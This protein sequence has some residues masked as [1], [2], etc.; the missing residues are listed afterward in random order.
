[1]LFKLIRDREKGGLVMAKQN[2]ANSVAND[3]FKTIDL[4]ASQ[5]INRLEFDK[6]MICTITKNNEAK[7]GIYTVSDGSIEFIAYSED[8]NYKVNTKVYVKI[9]NGDMAN[10]KIITSKYIDENSEYIDYIAPLDSFIDISGNLIDES[11]TVS[12][13]A[14][15]PITN[16][17]LWECFDQSF[18][19]YSKLGLKANFKTLLP[20]SI[21]SGNYGL[22]LDI[23]EITRAGS[24]KNHSYVLDSSNMFGN[25]YNFTSFYPQEILFDISNL[26]EII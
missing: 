23:T 15:S 17:L 21:K 22:K 5:Q 13:R 8:V 6:T 9:P 18:K 4:L 20:N 14:N 11:S 24:S 3:L 2:L 12:L 7:K 25:P 19:G 1:M 26:Y 10:Q 16:K